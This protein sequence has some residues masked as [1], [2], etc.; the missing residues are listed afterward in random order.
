MSDVTSA[1]GNGPG[2]L[3]APPTDTAAQTQAAQ[4]A[5]SAQPAPPMP[6]SDPSLHST[7]AT[8]DLEMAHLQYQPSPAP[9]PQPSLSADRTP[10]GLP[11]DVAQSIS[12][13]IRGVAKPDETP[14]PINTLSNQQIKETFASK[15]IA[16]QQRMVESVTGEGNAPVINGKLYYRHPGDSSLKEVP[17]SLAPAVVQ[18]ANGDHSMLGGVLQEMGWSG[19]KFAAGFTGAE[20]GGAGG[21]LMGGAAITA[22]AQ[23]LGMEGLAAGATLGPAGAVIGGIGGAAIG[24]MAGIYWGAKN[25]Q[26]AAAASQGKLIDDQLAGRIDENA[27]DEAKENGAMTLMGISGMKAAYGFGSFM[28]RVSQNFAMNRLE[29]SLD[30]RNAIMNF[31]KGFSKADPAQNGAAVAGIIGTAA[32][33]GALYNQYLE[34]W[35]TVGDD[36]MEQTGQRIDLSPIIAKIDDAVKR[37]VVFRGDT[38]VMR[39][40][41]IEPTM[42][43]IPSE[44]SSAQ[45]A[46]ANDASLPGGAMPNPPSQ[47]ESL[48]S[49]LQGGLFDDQTTNDNILGLPNGR[50]I[51]NDLLKRRADLA[52]AQKLNGGYDMASFKELQ[53]SLQSQADF[54]MMGQERLE[55]GVSTA[56]RATKTE[57]ALYDKL[58]GGVIESRN[59]FYQNLFQG[60]DSLMKAYKSDYMNYG[61]ARDA[62]NDLYPIFGRDGLATDE[63]VKNAIKTG[64]I[65]ALDAIKQLVGED[66]AVMNRMKAGIIQ[67]VLGEGL[68]N[69]LGILDTQAS[70]RAYNGI[71]KDVI[72]SIFT[73]TESGQFRALLLRAGK[74]STSD[75]IGAADKQ[76]AQQATNAIAGAGIYGHAT[77]QTGRLLYSFFGQNEKAYDYMAKQ[78]LPKMMEAAKSTG[79]FSVINSIGSLIQKMSDYRFLSDVI[80]RPDGS[81]ALKPNAILGQIFK[82]ATGE[83]VARKAIGADEPPTHAQSQTLH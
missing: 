19:A 5:Q 12:N 46:R 66:P 45:L 7:S 24:A 77:G 38:P 68:N 44:V 22:G 21:S 37:H 55:A 79:N 53:S 64:G 9:S 36:A 54:G 35:E 32:K 81:R 48:P 17:A 61:L 27:W 47:S 59:G 31:A 10:Q 65:H 16:G 78:A 75:M 43:S 74:L 14:N 52:R 58:Y 25:Q 40:T 15:D 70:F 82:T 73:P 26:M 1:F 63:M 39:S 72:D 28:S 2:S 60:N 33:P 41:G 49:P 50:A 62:W 83:A 71:K 57:L 76:L 51:L 13:G 42:P 6:S 67:H 80:E 3:S 56:N 69:P 23:A 4:G 30:I 11:D 29:S 18:S 20:L 8:A 34:K